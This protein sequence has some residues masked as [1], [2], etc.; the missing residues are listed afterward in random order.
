MFRVM[1]DGQVHL[2]CSNQ[3]PLG[4]VRSGD[5]GAVW[6]GR[7]A[8]HIRERIVAG[9]YDGAGC[10]GCFFWNAHRTEVAWFPEPDVPLSREQAQNRLVQQAEYEAGATT[11]A[12]LP[13]VTF[14]QPSYACNMACIM[15]NQAAVR[16]AGDPLGRSPKRLVDTILELEV[17][18]EMVILQGGEPFV[19]PEALRVLQGLA[20]RQAHTR[21]SI[22]TNGSLLHHHWELL[23]LLPYLSVNVSIDAG[24]ASTYG[25]IRVGGS[26]ERLR[27]NLDELRERRQPG[28]ILRAQHVLLRENLRTLP[29][30]L[31]AHES[32]ADQQRVFPVRG[33]EHR[34]QNVFCYH[35]LLEKEHGWE[36]ALDRAL[37][38]A[39]SRGDTELVGE[40]QYCLAL[41][42]GP[43]PLTAEVLS[44]LQA[45]AP[46]RQVVM[47]CDALADWRSDTVSGLTTGGPPIARF[48]ALGRALGL[49]SCE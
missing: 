16:A 27:A 11:L 28:W 29:D 21:V 14:V 44:R 3:T 7:P 10:G 33:A 45:E 5:R 48:P 17:Q 9:D 23:E 36:D 1:T 15:C 2:C 26:W 40:L 6:N 18:P 37:A 25:R 42:T 43:H 32:W 34:T 49:P 8:Q 30:L 20:D 24:D 38:W 12:S 4:D 31:L 13:S 41:L 35:H 22:N 39:Q 19:S 46:R 47:L